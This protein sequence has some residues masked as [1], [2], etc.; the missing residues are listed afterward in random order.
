MVESF[1]HQPRGTASKAQEHREGGPRGLLAREPF[2]RLFERVWLQAGCGG[3]GT[4]AT[5]TPAG[6]A[7][8]VIVSLGSGLVGPVG[9][10]TAGLAVSGLPVLVICASVTLAGV[11]APMRALVFTSLSLTVGA[12]QKNYNLVTASL[13]LLTCGTTW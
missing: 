10:S 5:A 8:G 1:S 9:Q 2:E 7:V 6:L 3:S 11:G 13:G 4:Y 12:L